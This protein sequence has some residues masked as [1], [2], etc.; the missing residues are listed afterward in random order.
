[1]PVEESNRIHGAQPDDYGQALLKC[2]SMNAPCQRR[3]AKTP[4]QPFVWLCSLTH[5]TQ[6][7]GGRIVNHPVDTKLRQWFIQV[8]E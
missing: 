7:R 3:D 4:R 2:F 6:M 8:V 5:K 1:M